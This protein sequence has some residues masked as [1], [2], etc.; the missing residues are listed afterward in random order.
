MYLFETDENEL[1][2]I[3]NS[4]DNKTLAGEDENCN[5]LVKTTNQN[6]APL[7][8]YLINLPFKKRKFFGEM[9][10]KQKF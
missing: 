10:K 2:V 3:I 8:T 4:L 7:L 5:A 6:V 9:K 1:I